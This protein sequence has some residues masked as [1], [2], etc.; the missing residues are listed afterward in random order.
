VAYYGVKATNVTS[1][2]RALTSVLPRPSI[3]LAFGSPKAI[4][5]RSL[6]IVRAEYRL[7]K[8]GHAEVT[9]RDGAKPR[10]AVR[11]PHRAQESQAADR[12]R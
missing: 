2:C 5:S 7:R 1:R 11:A 4:K 8:E 9:R 10:S 12:E 3:R 6:E